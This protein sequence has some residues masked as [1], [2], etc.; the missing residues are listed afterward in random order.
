[1]VLAFILTIIGS[2]FLAYG[3]TKPVV[4]FLLNGYGL[5]IRDNV[6]LFAGMCVFTLLNYTGQRFVAFKKKPSY[7]KVSGQIGSKTRQF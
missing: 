3:I 6:S 2:Y 5:K 1:M 7:L 4:Y